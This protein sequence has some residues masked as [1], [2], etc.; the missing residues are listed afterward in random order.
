MSQTAE[1]LPPLQQADL[2]PATFAQLIDDIEQFGAGVDISIKHTAQ[3]YAPD[4]RPTLRQAVAML[5]QGQVRGIQVR[6]THRGSAWCDTLIRVGPVTRL[7][8]IA[9]R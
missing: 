5:E 3:Q 6:Y 9:G 8:R 1:P 2:D 7:V 4:D